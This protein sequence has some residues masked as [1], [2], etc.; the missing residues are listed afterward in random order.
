MAPLRT[1][2][3]L[4]QL[5]AELRA[6]GIK[7]A[8]IALALPLSPQEARGSLREMTELIRGLDQALAQLG[9]QR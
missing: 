8:R 2:D 3:E 6:N 1:N 4:D 5:K 9:F 7:L